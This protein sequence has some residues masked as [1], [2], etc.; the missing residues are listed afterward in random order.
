M[1]LKNIAVFIA[2]DEPLIA[3]ELTLAVEAA[4]GQ[5]VG[6][7]ASLKAADQLIDASTPGV[8]LLDL[9]LIGGDTINLATGLMRRGI[10]VVFYTGVSLPDEFQE[11]YPD[12]PIYTKPTISETL[13]KAIRS[14]W[15]RA[16]A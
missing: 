12:V 11:R 2:E 1:T 13:I 9:N 7:A 5:I 16:A 8:A 3:I 10:P 4:C 14:E 6:P 15:D